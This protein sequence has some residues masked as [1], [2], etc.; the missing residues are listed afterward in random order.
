MTYGSSGVDFREESGVQQSISFAVVLSNKPNDSHN[1]DDEKQGEEEFDKIGAVCLACLT[2]LN[3][4][5]LGELY[6]KI[7]TNRVGWLI[8]PSCSG[9]SI[10]NIS[11]N[12]STSLLFPR[13]TCTTLLSSRYASNSL[14]RVFSSLAGKWV[15]MN[16]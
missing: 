5:L 11:A 2:C 8:F 3:N 12:L 14:C 6:C 1:Y 15:M 4:L 16:N 9:N 10:F 7:S 13:I